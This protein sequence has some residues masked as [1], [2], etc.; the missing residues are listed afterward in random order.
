M[1][2]RH[3][4]WELKFVDQNGYFYVHSRQCLATD[5]TERCTANIWGP[6]DTSGRGVP[7]QGGNIPDNNVPDLSD[8]QIVSLE[9][10]LAQLK[11]NK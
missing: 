10:I 7:I 5:Q 4:H 9:S 8:D 2:A 6:W 1:G 11:Q 3:E